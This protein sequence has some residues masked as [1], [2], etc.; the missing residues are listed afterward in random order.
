MIPALTNQWNTV[1]NQTLYFLPIPYKIE[2][3]E[4]DIPPLRSSKNP[5]IPNA[6]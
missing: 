5:S 2:P 3:I 6:L 4:K 1:W